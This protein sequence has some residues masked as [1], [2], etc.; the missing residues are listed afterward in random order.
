MTALTHADALQFVGHLRSMYSG[1]E[2]DTAK[3]ESYATLLETYDSQAVIDGLAHLMHSYQA[4]SFP[5]W[6]VVE[7]A[8]VYASPAYGAW[9][10]VSTAL[11][12]GSV[13]PPDWPDAAS[14]AAAVAMGGWAVF[15]DWDGSTTLLRETFL[16]RYADAAQS[17]AAALVPRLGEGRKHLN[18][19]GSDRCPYCGNDGWVELSGTVESLGMT[20]PLGCTACRWCEL[21]Q[22]IYQTC[23]TGRRAKGR[24]VKPIPLRSEYTEADLVDRPAE[25]AG[26]RWTLEEYAAS[27]AG[28]ADPALRDPKVREM[29]G[30]A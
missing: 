5:P 13:S 11:D 9:R 21:G 28:R 15:T 24:K 29:I 1:G 25:S 17:E 4:Q 3:I 2:A 16:R 30:L 26:E 14:R 20:Y 7:Q 23:T 18:V 27:N 10:L 12:A 22:V 6:A 8:I 19:T